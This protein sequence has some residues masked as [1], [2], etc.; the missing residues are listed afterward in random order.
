VDDVRGVLHLLA[1][2]VEL[3]VHHLQGV[4][5]QAHAALHHIH[6]RLGE[7]P[8]DDD[9]PSLHRPPRQEALL[10]LRRLRPIEVPVD[11][12]MVA[13]QEGLL[14]RPARDVEGL[15]DEGV[16][17]AQEDGGDDQRLRVLPPDGP[18]AR[19]R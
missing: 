3:L 11:E 8:E 1:I 14:H 7:G 17:E 9:V 4:A 19:G 18:A 15:Q 10:Q 2:Q 12:E 5:G 13:H 16:G 6:P